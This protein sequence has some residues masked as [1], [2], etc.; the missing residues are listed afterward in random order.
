MAI[1]KEEIEHLA[2]LARISLAPEEIGS[3]EKEF[4]S[5]LEFV[6]SL[7]EVDTK[8]IPPIISASGNLNVWREDGDS[9]EPIGD[10]GELQESFIKKDARGN[11][12][13]PRIFDHGN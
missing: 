7:K 9:I 5:I 3:F 11:L 12:T 13:V 8:E 1:T 4:I 6:A 2:E 10:T